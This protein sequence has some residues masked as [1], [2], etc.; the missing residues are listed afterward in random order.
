MSGNFSIDVSA[1]GA[2]G[3]HRDKSD[4][5]R[6]DNLNLLLKGLDVRPLVW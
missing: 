4:G 1:F 5:S 3:D 6:C 2:I